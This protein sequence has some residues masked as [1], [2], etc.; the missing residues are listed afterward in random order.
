MIGRDKGDSLLR[1]DPQTWNGLVLHGVS[2]PVDWSGW[3]AEVTTDNNH[4]FILTA[5]HPDVALILLTE[6]FSGFTDRAD[7]S[8]DER[9][10]LARAALMRSIDRLG[11]KLGQM[12]ELP[13]EVGKSLK[14][15][16]V[17]PYLTQHEL[18]ELFT[19]SRTNLVLGETGFLSLALLFAMLHAAML[20]LP[21]PTPQTGT[22]SS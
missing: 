1:Y 6:K 12:E 8:P 15:E 3:R 20:I 18:E 9:S 13:D 22:P 16:Y 2:T 4:P 21:P 5:R 7:A 17:G 19:Q 14:A 10:A 11:A